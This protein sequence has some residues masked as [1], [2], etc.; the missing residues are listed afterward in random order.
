MAYWK[1]TWVYQCSPVDSVCQGRRA[2]LGMGVQVFGDQ[3][4]LQPLELVGAQSLRQ[5]H[6]VIDVEGHPAVEHEF[7]VV[8]D[9]LAHAGDECLIPLQPVESIGRSIRV[10][11]LVRGE[12][13]FLIPIDIVAGGVAIDLVLLQ[14]ADQAVNGQTERLALGIP[15][16]QIHGA[17]GVGSQA[18]RA[19]RFGQAKHHIRQA[20]DGEAV[21]TQQLWRQV[22][23]N[24]S[25]DWPAVAGP[26]QPPSAVLE[27]YL[28]I[29]ALP[30]CLGPFV[31]MPLDMTIPGH[32]I[33]DFVSGVP[34]WTAGFGAGLPRRQI[35]PN[36][37][38]MLYFH[39]D[40][41]VNV[42]ELGSFHCPTSA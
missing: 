25:S 7:A 17:D 11:Q 22:I 31:A 9:Q 15:E 6:G 41:L 13:H 33:G 3:A 42:I 23:V 26:A 40:I 18:Y 12:S 35:D 10:R 1:G 30:A 24:D 37:F 34:G 2:Q 4:F 39:L 19:V 5:A 32:G 29:N 38:D 28:G 27:R 21:L 16:R 36:R 8:A 14:T 20:L